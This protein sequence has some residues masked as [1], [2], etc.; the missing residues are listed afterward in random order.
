MTTVFGDLGN[1]VEQLRKALLGRYPFL[2]PDGTQVPVTGNAGLHLAQIVFEYDM[3]AWHRRGG[4]GRPPQW[5]LFFRQA[6]LETRVPD[7]DE[8]ADAYQQIPALKTVWRMVNDHNMKEDL[9]LSRPEMIPDLKPAIDFTPRDTVKIRNALVPWLQGPDGRFYYQNAIDNGRQTV[10]IRGTSDNAR[11]LADAEAS[12][13]R[14]ASLYFIDA[15]MC[16]LLMSAY[17][18]MPDFAPAPT[19]LPS[20]YGFAIFAAP[21]SFHYNNP[22]AGPNGRVSENV[23]KLNEAGAQ[24]MAVTWRPHQQPQRGFEWPHGGVWFTWYAIPA[25]KALAAQEGPDAAMWKQRSSWIPADLLPENES[26]LAWFRPDTGMDE[27]AYKAVY[28]ASNSH[29]KVLLAAFQLARQANVAEVAT[30]HVA[31]RP[32]P[33]SKARRGQTAPPGGDI[34]VVRLR[35]AIAAKR[36]SQ[37]PEDE[38]ARRVYQHRWVVRGFWRNTWYPKSKLNRP[39]WIAPYVKGPKGAPLKKPATTVTLVAPPRQPV[40][41]R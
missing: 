9:A 14:Q 13:L 10:F 40:A 23:R 41:D 16:Q 4:I 8:L 5:K 28:T 18:S 12:A 22:M 35:A 2:L 7:D 31:S 1:P 17:P 19:D 24:I 38:G 37:A 32:V 30:E 36:D 29:T 25:S 21:I 27:E 33:K 6:G 34:K 11:A 39:Q 3:K 20:E 15:D 26:A